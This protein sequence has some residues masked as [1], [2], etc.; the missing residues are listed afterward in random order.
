LC[1]ANRDPQRRIIKVVVER[2][3]KDKMSK[4]M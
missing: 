2:D 4:E 1:V 3:G